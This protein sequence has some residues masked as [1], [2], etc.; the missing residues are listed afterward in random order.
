MLLL[1]LYTR[2]G[3]TIE[4]IAMKRP[5]DGSD[6]KRPILKKQKSG[7][8]HRGPLRLSHKQARVTDLLANPQ[9]A[10]QLDEELSR[11]ICVAL[12]GTGFDAVTMSALES[13]R[14]ATEECKSQ[15]IL[16]RSNG[17]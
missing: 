7:V 6:G 5:S 1:G 10:A 9:N 16:T 3:I 13:F 17:A 15:W 11:A 2:L 12:Y 4:P 8:A 14:A